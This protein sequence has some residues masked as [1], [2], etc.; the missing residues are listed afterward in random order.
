V[1]LMP[2]LMGRTDSRPHQSLC[3]R[4]G[5]Q[6]AIRDGDWKLVHFEGFGEKLFDLS[7]DIGEKHDLSVTRP[8]VASRMKGKFEAWS[9]QMMKPRWH[10][11]PKFKE[12][13]EKISQQK[14]TRGKAGEDGE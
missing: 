4:F 7:K 3:W 14:A 9:A 11:K 13:L 10:S 5:E 6:W 12:S 1:D 2:L 8:E